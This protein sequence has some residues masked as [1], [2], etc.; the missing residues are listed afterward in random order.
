M[1]ISLFFIVAAK[2]ILIPG[3]WLLLLLHNGKEKGEGENWSWRIHS[4]I[5]IS[6]LCA[7]FVFYCQRI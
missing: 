7:K 5:H 1:F 2:S 6:I 3:R 4:K